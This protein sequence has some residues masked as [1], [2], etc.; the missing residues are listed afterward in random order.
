MQQVII[1]TSSR[2]TWKL[3]ARAALAMVVIFLAAIVV[4]AW[5][6]PFSR[7]AVLQELEDASQSR[8]HVVVFHG[9]YFP[10]PGCVLEHVTFQH[11]PRAGSPPLITVER[12]RIEGSFSGLFRKRVRRVR[13]EGMRVQIPPRGSD[14]HFETPKRSPVVID[15]LSADGAILEVASREADKQPL[16]FSFHNFVLSDVGS[17]GPASFHARLS[18]PEPPGEITTSGKFGPWNEDD[19]GKTAVSGEYLF[20][21]ADLGVFR[22]IAGLLSSSGKFSGMLDRIEVQGLTDTPSFTV[23]SS[24]HQVQLRTQFLC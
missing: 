20:Q 22:G 21:R 5:R 16:K 4:L 17:N 23:T 9:M 6:W 2:K 19:V 11:N 24:S 12:L 13:A 10:R 1:P 3:I 7:K 18:N 8:V 15:D 14:A